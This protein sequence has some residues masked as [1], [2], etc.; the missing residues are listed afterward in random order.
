MEIVVVVSF[1]FIM[2]VDENVSH[3]ETKECILVNERATR[4]PALGLTNALRRTCWF[5]RHNSA[6]EVLISY[7]DSEKQQ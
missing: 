2:M 6:K 7:N 5:V 3:F 1:V 4:E